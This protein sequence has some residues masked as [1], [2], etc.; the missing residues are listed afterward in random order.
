MNEDEEDGMLQSRVAELTLSTV[1]EIEELAEEILTDRAHIIS[2]DKKRNANREALRAIKVNPCEKRWVCFGNLFIKLSNDHSVS[3]I[4]ND[5][6]FLEKELSKV[7][8][9]LKPKVKKLHN[10]EGLPDVKGFD[11][12][13][14]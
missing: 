5:Q 9:A 7:H 4:K 2:C 14:I 12:K 10:L 3:L 1:T 11:L 8:D 13:G 6:E